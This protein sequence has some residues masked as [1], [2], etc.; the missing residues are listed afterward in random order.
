MISDMLGMASAFS[1][2]SSSAVDS[3]VDIKGSDQDKP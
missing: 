1:L 3:G 2:A